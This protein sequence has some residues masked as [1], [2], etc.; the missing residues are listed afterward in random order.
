MGWGEKAWFP[1]LSTDL[2][3]QFQSNYQSEKTS[4]PKKSSSKVEKYYD[5]NTK[6]TFIWNS[7]SN[8]WVPMNDERSFKNPYEYKDPNTGK[9]YYWNESEKTWGETKVDSTSYTD[10]TTGKVYNW[11]QAKY[12]WECEDG[13]VLLP[14]TGSN[15]SQASSTASNTTNKKKRNQTGPKSIGGKKSKAEWF[16]LEK[17]KNTSV[18]VSGLPLDI[19]LEEF[20]EMMQKYG[21]IQTNPTT[22]Q[23]KIKLYYDKEGNLKGD[24][25]CNYLK[26]ESVTLAINMLHESKMR[27][28]SVVKVQPAKFELKGEYDPTKKPKMLSKKEKKQIQKQIDK[29]LDWKLGSSE[30]VSKY[31]KVV[32]F[33]NLFKPSIFDTNPVLITEIKD[34]LRSQCEAFGT[35]KKVVLFDRHCEG[36]CSVAFKE[37]KDAIT[38]MESLNGRLFSGNKIEASLWD[39]VTD[40]Q[41]EETDLEREER[42]K[43]W[44]NYLTGENPQSSDE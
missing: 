8:Q 24:G 9:M 4:D 43:N 29:K 12:V 31:D 37:V 27:Q 25:L 1:K 6:T 39:G 14:S 19:T 28:S 10:P 23:L 32:I 41:I 13:S 7:E 30:K 5:P 17:Q 2:L 44:Q 22:N 35:V 16:D 18:Y 21:I 26:K 3:V 36:V 15:T 38:C 42:L 40:Y 33:K 34:D 20:T 11:N